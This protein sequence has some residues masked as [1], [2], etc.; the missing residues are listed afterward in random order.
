[1]PTPAPHRLAELVACLS[2]SSDSTAQLALD[3][4]GDP[5]AMDHDPLAAVASALVA[6]RRDELRSLAGAGA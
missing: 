1:M 4:T 6:I 2:G 5:D 3:H